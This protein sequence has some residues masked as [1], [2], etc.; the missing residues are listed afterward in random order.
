MHGA[1]FTGSGER[2]LKGKVQVDL[3]AGGRLRIRTASTDIGQGTE[4]VFRQIAADSLRHAEIVAALSANL[5]RGITTSGPTGIDRHEVEL[6]LEREREAES[7][8]SAGLA[9]E[10]GGVMRILWESMEAD[11]RKHE[12]LLR[13][14][15][16]TGFPTPPAP[17]PGG[18]ARA[19]RQSDRSPGRRPS[20][21]G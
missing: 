15:I 2:R 9:E 19:T 10:L 3:E 8:E 6:L 1:G 16:A 14:L 11:E 20:P 13:R 5:D 18:R 17:S 21:V 7:S 12:L 4:T